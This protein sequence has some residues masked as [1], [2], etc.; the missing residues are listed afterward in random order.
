LVVGSQER[1][2]SSED[3]VVE[4]PEDGGDEVDSTRCVAVAL[5]VP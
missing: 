2:E 4:E 1:P 3:H 5:M